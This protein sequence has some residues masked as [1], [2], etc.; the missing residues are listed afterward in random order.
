MVIVE[1]LTENDEIAL[2][3]RDLIKNKGVHASALSLSFED[4]NDSCPTELS[5]EKASISSYDMNWTSLTNV[6]LDLL[7]LRS[8]SVI[9]DVCKSLGIQVEDIDFNR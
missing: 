9:D 3:L 6:K 5:S 2:K 8:V 4:M 7:G 1:E